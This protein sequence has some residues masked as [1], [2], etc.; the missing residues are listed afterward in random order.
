MEVAL[1]SVFAL[2]RKPIFNF[3]VTLGYFEGLCSEIPYYSYWK[4]QGTAIHSI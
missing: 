4:L 2:I 3:Y 1:K